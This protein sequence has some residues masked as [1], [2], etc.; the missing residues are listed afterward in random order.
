MTRT[1]DPTTLHFYTAQIGFNM[2]GGWLVF[3]HIPNPVALIGMMA[4]CGA[5][6]AWLALHQSSRR[7]ISPT[8]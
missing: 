4:V 7:L 2:L 3:S 8:S 6:D 1:E 5:A